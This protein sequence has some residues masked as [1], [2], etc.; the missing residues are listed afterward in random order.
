MKTVKG[1][2]DSSSLFETGI[3]L[4]VYRPKS[5]LFLSLGLDIVFLEIFLLR[6]LRLRRFLVTIMRLRWER[7]GATSVAFHIRR[8]RPCSVAM[9]QRNKLG[10]LCLCSFDFH[11][12]TS[13]KSKTKSPRPR[14]KALIIELIDWWCLGLTVCWP[15]AHYLERHQTCLLQ[16]VGS[17]QLST[18]HGLMSLHYHL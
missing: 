11:Y 14:L 4:R 9:C 15:L 8:T 17:V 5:R 1:W 10:C 7:N 3:K 16:S 18:H 6:T 13:H 2:Q 12:S